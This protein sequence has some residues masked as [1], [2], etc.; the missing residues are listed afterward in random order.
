VPQPRQTPSS[1]VHL[2][3]EY[4][5]LAR[6]GGL[7]EAVAGIAAAEASDLPTTVVLPLYRAIRHARIDLA[8]L[9][10]EFQISLGARE[11]AGRLWE[12]AGDA[13]GPR[14]VLVEHE[15]FFDRPGLYGENGNGDYGDNARRF[16]FFTLAALQ[17]LPVLAPGP[18]VIHAHDWHTALAPVLLR[19]VLRGDPR[20]DSIATLVTVHNAAFQGHFPRDSL[21]DLALPDTLYDWRALEWYGRVNWL[22]GGLVFTDMATTVSP[23]HAGEL[24]T[25]AGGFGLHD[26]FVA[27]GDRFTGVL[28]GIADDVW[29]PAR[30]GNL[31]APY[32]ADDVTGKARCKVALQRAYGLPDRPDTPVVVMSARLVAQK[33]FDLVLASRLIPAAHAQFVFLGMGEP[34][35]QRALAGLAQA[36]PQ[37]VATDFDYSDWRE[38]RLL[39]GADILLMP[40]LYEPCGLTQMRAQRY[41]ALPVARRTGGLADT[42]LD[43]ESGFLFDDYTPQALDG[44]LARA[45]ARH[46]QADAWA[47]RVRA[48]MTRDFGWTTSARRYVELYRRALRERGRDTVRPAGPPGGVARSHPPRARRVF[49]NVG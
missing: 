48:A 28:N 21:R 32:S 47:E 12:V 34:R 13:G 33:G 23:T 8:P 37:R 40:S 39:A 18:A 4:W 11:E 24:R 46:A 41:G 20:Y 38:Q 30:P 6:T 1:I 42:I 5:P 16:A 14:L 7:G 15:G 35:Y 3:A 49:V 43:D 19:T 44:A 27:L 36:A 29:N 9:G 17:S 22:K 45:L 26:A 10:P 31:E 2:T 25:A